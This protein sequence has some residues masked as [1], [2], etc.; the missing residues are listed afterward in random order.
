MSLERSNLKNTR[1]NGGQIDNLDEPGAKLL[2]V[3]LPIYIISFDSWR[4]LAPKVDLCPPKARI[5]FSIK[6]GFRSSHFQRQPEIRHNY[7]VLERVIQ[8]RDNRRNVLNEMN[9]IRY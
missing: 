6:T 8:L 1:P 2:G 5:L 7:R 4:R 9:W 3:P